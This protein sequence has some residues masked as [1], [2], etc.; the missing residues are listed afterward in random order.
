MERERPR[1]NGIMQYA[2]KLS[3]PSSILMFAA[4]GLGGGW[5][6]FLVFSAEASCARQKGFLRRYAVAPSTIP[7]SEAPASTAFDTG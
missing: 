7:V 1:A 4:A 6:D 5:G 2:Q 3:Q